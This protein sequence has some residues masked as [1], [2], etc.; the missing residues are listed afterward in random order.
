MQFRRSGQRDQRRRKVFLEDVSADADKS[1]TPANKTGKSDAVAKAYAQAA[2]EE[3]ETRVA[4]LI[5][6][7]PLGVFV[8][9][10]L[11]LT[12]VA[13]VQALYTFLPDWRGALGPRGSAAFDLAGSGSVNGWLSAVLLGVS[14]MMSVLIYIIRRHKM[15]DYRGRYRMWLWAAAGLMLA[16][17]NA[18]A[19]LHH[20]FDA[21]LVRL[22][23]LTLFANAAGW[24][25]IGI[26]FVS[27][28]FGLWLLIDM[29]RS[30]GASAAL[31]SAAAIYV[32]A[33]ALLLRQPLVHDP[34]LA[35]MVASLAFSLG[36]LTLALA[37]TVYARRVLLEARGLLKVE[38]KKPK[39]KR[40]AP[41]QD[42]SDAKSDAKPKGR[43]EKKAGNR[44]VKIDPPH[45]QGGGPSKAD[46]APANEE[47]A[48]SAKASSQPKQAG[49]SSSD[50][51]N[52]EADEHGPAEGSPEWRQLSKSQR[53]RLKKL[54]RRKA[55]AAS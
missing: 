23:G 40:A 42:E 17:V 6:T 18:V 38:K 9:F 45:R 39:K 21:V 31:L 22:S 51:S 52:G 7:R 12:A 30:R 29:W 43:K 4:D 10:L 20:A 41:D 53:R 14:A 2:I 46:D 34:M 3:T 11:G 47:N 36:H 49:R 55:A 25:L 24:S 48:K 33:A 8:L 32:G 37:F 16:S 15:D 13:V 5:P 28:V 44:N 35:T 50:H 26:S 27:G 54:R 19:G 1:A